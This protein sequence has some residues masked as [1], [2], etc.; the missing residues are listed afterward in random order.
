MLRLSVPLV[1]SMA[2]LTVM[3]FMDRMFLLWHSEQSVAAVLPAGM[4]HFS[5]I[6]FPLGL[7]SYVNTFVAQYH[8]A[9]QEH[10]IGPAAWQGARVG[11]Y[12]IPLYLL[13]IP[14]APWVFRLAGHGPGLAAE[15][16]LF[17]QV[18]T[19]G[20]G[21][22]IMAAAF[23]AVFTGIGATPVVMVVD[24]TAA[25]L[26]GVLDYG[27][28][29]GHFGLPELG[30]EGAG[31]ATVTA[32]WFRVVAYAALTLLPRYRRKYGLWEDRRFNGPLFGRLLRF[33]VP[34]GVQLLID[35]AGFT[36]FLLIVGQ[37]GSENAAATSLAFNVN[38]LAFV[39]ML[40][41]GLA[42]STMVG[43]QLGR[44]RPDLAS[45]ATWTSLWIAGG[46]MGAMALVYLLLPDVLLM[47][48]ALRSRPA[49]FAQLRATTV[50]LLRFVA[51]YC[52]FDSMNVVF[53]GALKGAGDTRFIMLVS[54]L[55]TPLPLLAAIVGIRYW[56]GGLLWCWTV[57]TIWVLTMAFIYAGRF[58]QGQWRHIRVIEPE[59]LAG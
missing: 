6:C 21:A 5:L 12:C 44:N 8:G 27:W 15:E 20:A 22:E 41:L 17:F 30:I 50:V 59:L 34:N 47:G 39:P 49:E 58:L 9:G 14:A 52:L 45:R 38:A 55:L 26:N 10:R 53:S 40:G 46:Y 48:H 43:R 16:T 33:G 7:A 36:L 24:S 4:L 25:L 29:F 11:L 23:S 31:W 32:L 56:G 51:A 19:F 2:A 37:L 13:L 57:M 54:L 35:V 1:T 3:T 28:I 18:C 42:L